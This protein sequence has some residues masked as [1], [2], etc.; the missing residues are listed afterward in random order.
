MR[1]HFFTNNTDRL[2]LTRLTHNFLTQLKF[3][4]NPELISVL[5]HYVHP[6][7]YVTTWHK[8]YFLIKEMLQLSL[9]KQPALNWKKKVG[10]AD[11]L[12]INCVMIQNPGNFQQIFFTNAQQVVCNMYLVQGTFS[13]FSC[14]FL[15][16]NILFQFEF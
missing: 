4:S 13:K 7:V 14:M 11:A 1:P 16:P 12:V 9:Q 5:T 2:F 8:K 15:N 3:D 10:V 6:I